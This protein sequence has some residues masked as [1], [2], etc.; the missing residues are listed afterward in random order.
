V[1]GEVEA[2]L[3]EK[4]CELYQENFELFKKRYQVKDYCTGKE[5]T[6][7]PAELGAADLHVYL[8]DFVDIVSGTS[9]GSILA[10][11][12]ATKG[13]TAY[14]NIIGNSKQYGGGISK[15]KAFISNLEAG[16]WYPTIEEK[17]DHTNEENQGSK[18]SLTPC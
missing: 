12:V 15:A 13:G 7:L 9:T 11:Y 4:L 17:Q 8:A 1:L 14:D 16:Q 6:A 3:K 2:A 18:G 5:V 10:A